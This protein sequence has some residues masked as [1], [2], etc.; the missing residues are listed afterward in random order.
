MKP[1]KGNVNPPNIGIYIPETITSPAPK[2][3]PED[4][5]RVYGDASSFFNTDCTTEPL[6][7]KH[8]PTINA[9]NTL[10]A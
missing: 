4:T 6:V 8:P 9:N 7:A 5:P 10:E 1:I 3:A 2:D